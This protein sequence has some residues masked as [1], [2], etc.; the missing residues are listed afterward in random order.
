MGSC[1]ERKGPG[2]RIFAKSQRTGDILQEKLNR[3]FG[4]SFKNEPLY[5]EEKI[6]FFSR[7]GGFSLDYHKS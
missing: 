5:L 7:Y 3:T 6:K 4:L 1:S 2:I